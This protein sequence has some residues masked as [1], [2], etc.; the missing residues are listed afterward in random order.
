MKLGATSPHW[1]F[2]VIGG[3]AL[4]WNVGGIANY[5]MQVTDAA[6]LDSYRAS[7]RAIIEGRPAWATGAFALAV[8][9]GGL[10]CVLLLLRKLVAIWALTVSLIGVAV[11]QF[12]ALSAGI[13]FSMGEIAGIIL[14][15]LL[16]PVLLIIYAR[17]AKRRGWID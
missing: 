2:W 6:V 8:F 3:L 14:V 12:H 16:M 1:S 13:T 5:V 7:E 11:T 9:S 17:Y 4:I 10:G 15:P